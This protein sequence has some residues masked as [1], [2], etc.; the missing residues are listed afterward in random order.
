MELQP[1]IESAT[2]RVASDLIL[3][4]AIKPS[5]RQTTVVTVLRKNH[6]A[7]IRRSTGIHPNGRLRDALAQA[8]SS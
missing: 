6:L 1:D 2:P 4:L 5:S 8:L 3:I 7:R